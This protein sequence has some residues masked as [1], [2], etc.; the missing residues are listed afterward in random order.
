MELA[1]SLAFVHVWP[2]YVLGVRYHFSFGVGISF[3]FRLSGCTLSYFYLLPASSFSCRF[4][5]SVQLAGSHHPHSQKPEKPPSSAGFPTVSLW[6][7]R[8]ATS[9][10]WPSSFPVHYLIWWSYS[11]PV[12]KTA[13]QLLPGFL[14]L[15]GQRTD[16]NIAVWF[17][18]FLL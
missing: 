16:S 14:L 10:Q 15:L 5:L 1:V 12:F 13:P 17:W 8:Q 18:N 4:A 2:Y 11:G 9:P 3:V 7:I 6:T